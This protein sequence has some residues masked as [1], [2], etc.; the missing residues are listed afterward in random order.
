MYKHTNTLNTLIIDMMS[1]KHNKNTSNQTIQIAKCYR[2]V[3]R[4]VKKYKLVH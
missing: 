2:K 3:H 4:H 1:L